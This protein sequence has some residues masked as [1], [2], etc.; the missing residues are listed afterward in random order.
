MIVKDFINLVM[1]EPLLLFMLFVFSITVLS[2][3]YIICNIY[4]IL[5]DINLQLAKLEHEIGFDTRKG[6]FT[7]DAVIEI[8][9]KIEMLERKQDEYNHER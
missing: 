4:S 2:I 3:F 6:N 8:L 5:S 1:D 9:G 7:C